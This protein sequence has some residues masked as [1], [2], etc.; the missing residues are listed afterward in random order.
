MSEQTRYAAI[1][2]SALK[3]YRCAHTEVPIDA[4]QAFAKQ[5]FQAGNPP[6]VER[7]LTAQSANNR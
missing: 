2:D 1:N 3:S 6:L 5:I 7:F 4:T